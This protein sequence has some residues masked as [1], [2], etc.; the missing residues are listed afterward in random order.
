M[1]WELCRLMEVWAN[2]TVINILQHTV[3]TYVYRIITLYPLNLYS[4]VCQLYLN[5]S[6]G[7]IKINTM[8]PETLKEKRDAGEKTGKVQIMSEV[9]LKKKKK[10]KIKL[11]KRY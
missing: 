4:V 9:S 10:V 7:K 8:R 5:K 3:H 6:G 2:P 11:N 1:K